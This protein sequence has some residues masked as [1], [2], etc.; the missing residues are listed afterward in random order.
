MESVQTDILR[1]KIE[2][3]LWVLGSLVAAFYT[4]VL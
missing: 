4:Y 2:L 3:A 1:N